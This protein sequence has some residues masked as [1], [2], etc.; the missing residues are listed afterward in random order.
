MEMFVI[1]IVVMV[2][3]MLSSV[4]TDTI[5]HL[6]YVQF[7][8]LQIYLNK[9]EKK[10]YLTSLFLQLIQYFLALSCSKTP[11]NSWVHSLLSSLLFSFFN[12]LPAGL[13][14]PI[15]PPTLLLSRSQRT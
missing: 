8:I 14:H 15:T 7:I 1:L 6:E 2:S 9:I 3:Q 10:F 4:K 12:L 13:S 11:L 5:V